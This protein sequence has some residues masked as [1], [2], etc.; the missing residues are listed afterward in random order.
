M[1]CAQITRGRL[2]PAWA[3]AVAGLAGALIAGT[4]CGFAGVGHGAHAGGLHIAVRAGRLHPPPRAVVMTPPPV[5]PV[6]APPPMH[7]HGRFAFRGRFDRRD[8]IRRLPDGLGWVGGG[9]GVIGPAGP[10]EAT[11]PAESATCAELLTWSPRLGRATR[12]SLC[13]RDL[14]DW[15]PT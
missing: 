2:R 9:F 15:R 10:M 6:S 12:R 1:G 13:G 4:T 7:R 11:A 14:E 8:S 3:A 5:F